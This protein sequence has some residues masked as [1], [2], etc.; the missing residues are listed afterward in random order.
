MVLT[1]QQELWGMALW[2]EKHHSL[3]GH[4]YIERRIGELEVEGEAEGA[5][6]WQ[7]VATFYS[8]L[9]TPLIPIDGQSETQPNLR[10]PT[11]SKT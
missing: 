9:R 3:D 5:L 6:L 4:D 10:C 7:R 11:W 1:R 2:V 8:K